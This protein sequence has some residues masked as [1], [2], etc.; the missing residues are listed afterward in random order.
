MIENFKLHVFRV[1][2][3]TLSFSKAA[4]KLHLSQPA[5]TSQV[6]TLEEG[7]GIAL[8]DR[9]GR[10]A[11]L[12]PAGTTLLGYVR[13]IETLTNEAV[14]ALA[15]YGVQESAELNIG[16]AH[17]IAVYVLPRLL[18]QILRDWPKL[19]VHVLSGSSIEV[20]NA[21]ANHQVSLG[22]IE[23]PAHRPDFK[24]E[25]FMDDELCLILPPNHRWVKKTTLRAAEIVQEPILLRESGSGMRRFVEEYLERNGVLSQ[26][27]HTTVDMNSTEAILSAVEAGLGIGFVP[28]MALGKA[29]QSASVVAIPLENGPIKRQ[30]SIAM[31]GGPV[32][33]GPVR[34]L[35]ALLHSISPQSSNVAE[36]KILR[37]K[38]P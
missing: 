13:Q 15:P 11:K 8:F 32:T 36:K 20:L 2:A 17:T 24:I 26:Q 31:L 30:F 16:A 5:V 35:V 14:A 3:D 4:E 34:D 18:P 1:V 33:A 21:L 12:T 23:A 6:R 7:L 38:R 28:K 37:G 25:H 19:R 10:N 9:I 27:L 29:L 22:L